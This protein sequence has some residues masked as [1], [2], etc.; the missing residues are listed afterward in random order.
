MIETDYSRG[1]ERANSNADAIMML[2][3]LQFARENV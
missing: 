2:F 1:G 3:A